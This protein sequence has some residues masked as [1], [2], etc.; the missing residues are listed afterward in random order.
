MKDK[1]PKSNSQNLYF[2]RNEEQKNWP[3]IQAA[4]L[5]LYHLLTI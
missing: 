5:T 1:L 3:H 4:I 2:T